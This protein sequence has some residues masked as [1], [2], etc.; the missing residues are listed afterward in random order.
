MG[1]PGATMYDILS[2]AMNVLPTERFFFAGETASTGCLLIHGFAGIPSEMRGLGDYLAAQGYTVLGVR[3]AG[4][5]GS[6]EDLQATRW[7]DWLASAEAGLTELRQHCD[8]IVVIGFSMGGALALLLAHNHTFARLVLLATP[9]QIKG[10]WRLNFL[11][12]V[13]YAIPW[14]YPL[15][16]ADFNKPF[17]QQRVREF[18]PDA[19]LSDPAVQ[20]NIRRSV[21][22]SVR[23][24]LE[25]QRLLRRARAVVPQVTIPTLVMHGRNDD[26]SPL[27]SA[28]ELVRRLG[29]QEKRL[30]W[31]EQ[32]GHHM[33]VG[34]HREAIFAQVA[35]F[36]AAEEDP[37]VVTDA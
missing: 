3:L 23:A 15:E 11:W 25:L 19:D 31:W 20:E 22:I 36:V 34:P 26:T 18:A 5:G 14:Y 24:V 28:E 35:A 7:Q 6:P 32:T 29:S 27:A 37:V 30:I 17:V 8:R 13:R 2:P 21:K 10:D 1:Y 16:K 9:L 12:A 4:H 33:M